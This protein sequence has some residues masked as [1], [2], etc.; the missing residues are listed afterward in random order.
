MKRLGTLA[1]LLFLWGSWLWPQHGRPG[2]GGGTAPPSAGQPGESHTPVVAVDCGSD[3]PLMILDSGTSALD[4]VGEKLVA[5]STMD[6]GSFLLP[7]F[8]P[9]VWWRIEVVET[10]KSVEGTGPSI[11]LECAEFAATPITFRVTGWAQNLGT[12]P[13]FESC[14]VADTTSWGVT[15]PLAVC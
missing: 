7:S 6:D 5:Y 2:V 10:S 8:G 11:L 1:V 4:G 12:N 15:D 14:G 13:E 3:T 9:I